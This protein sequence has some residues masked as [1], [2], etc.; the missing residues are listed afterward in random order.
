MGRRIVPKPSQEVAAILR[1]NGFELVR[2]ARHGAVY[3]HPDDP[4]RRTELPDRNPVGVGLICTILKQTRK[5][6]SDFE[7]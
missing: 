5:P 6:R 7:T 1:H 4:T 2:E 3:I